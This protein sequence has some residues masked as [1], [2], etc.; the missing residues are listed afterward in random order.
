MTEESWADDATVGVSDSIQQAADLLNQQLWCWG[1]DIESLEGNL[2]IQY[3]FQRIENPADSNVASLYRLNISP[4]TRIILR[5][6]GIF[7]GDDEWGGLFLRRFGFTPQL[8]PS[9]D[10]SAPLWSSEDLP[11]LVEPRTGQATNCQQLLLKLTAW[12]SRY[13]LWIEET[14]GVEYRRE[15]L[16]PWEAKGR[17]VIPA[18]E[19]PG[20]WCLLGEV[21]ANVYASNT[22]ESKR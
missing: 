14:I 11:P 12:V 19:M 8:T 13:E 4:T 3:G 2:L 22:A 18:E 10:L 5:G 9:S 17:I 6:F 20:S 16:E 1:C 15:M 7:F 21:M